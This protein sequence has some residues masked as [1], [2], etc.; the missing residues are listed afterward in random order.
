MCRLVS[1]NCPWFHRLHSSWMVSGVAATALQATYPSSTLSTTR[2]TDSGSCPSIYCNLIFIF[3]IDGHNMVR[4]FT[5]P[6]E[7]TSSQRSRSTGTST[8]R[9]LPLT[10]QHRMHLIRRLCQLNNFPTS[11]RHARR[12]DQDPLVPT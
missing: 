1:S 2:A 9:P 12:A 6:L 7:P 10:L 3:S 5:Q 11:R 8:T 4:I